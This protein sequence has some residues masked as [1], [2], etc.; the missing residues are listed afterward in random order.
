MRL[1]IDPSAPE[2]VSDQIREGVRLAIAGGDPRPGDALI[3]VRALARDLLVNP[4]TVAKAYR[5]LVRDGVLVSRNG[6]GV[7]VAPEAPA[8]CRRESAAAVRAALRA[9]VEK[10]VAAGLTGEEIEA[11]VAESLAKKGACA[12]VA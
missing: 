12:D 2:C 8:R 11:V 7:F 9:A 1:S 6:A 10:G 3:S 5:D 4:N